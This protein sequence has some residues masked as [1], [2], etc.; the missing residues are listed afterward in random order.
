M[1]REAKKIRNLFCELILTQVF[2]ERNLAILIR[3]KHIQGFLSHKGYILTVQHSIH[4]VLLFMIKQ[5]YD[6][7]GPLSRITC[8]EKLLAFIFF[9]PWYALLMPLATRFR[10]EKGHVTITW[11]INDVI[12]F[13]SS[14]CKNKVSSSLDK[15]ASLSVSTK[16]NLLLSRFCISL[17]SLRTSAFKPIERKRPFTVWY[18]WVKL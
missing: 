9:H 17:K 3:I 7:F 8:C 5:T 13:D 1:N 2:T 12:R 16:S 11:M 15:W 10:S 14:G 18:Y 4:D 6:W